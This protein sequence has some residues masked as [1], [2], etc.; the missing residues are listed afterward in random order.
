MD[1]GPV[2]LLIVEFPGN[3]FKGE[4]APALRDLVTEGTVRVLDLLFVYKDADG[5]VGSVELAGLGPD[6]QPAFAD[7]DGQLGGGLLDAE[8][9]AQVGADLQPDS[10]AALD[11]LGEHMGGPLRHRDGARRRPCRRPGPD[12][13]RGG[14]PRLESA[15]P[16]GTERH[17]TARDGRTHR[18]RRGHRDARRRQRPAPPTAPLGA[19][20]RGAAAAAATA[21]GASPAAGLRPRSRPTPHQRRRT[22]RLRRHRLRRPV[23][24]TWC[25]SCSG[26]GTC[27]PRAPSP[28]RSS[29]RP[30][31]SC[32]AADRVGVR[33]WCE[34]WT[35]SS[36]KERLR[37]WGASGS[38][39]GARPPDAAASG[40]GAGPHPPGD[41]ARRPDDDAAHP[42][43]DH[44]GGADPAG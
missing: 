28:T 16:K 39:A 24:T 25:R 38:R 43:A 37:A 10:S 42:C 31:P 41:G 27:T 14:R 23:G 29:R 6:L 5:E 33:A 44:A 12:P 2:D 21:A 32:S 40:H 20:G 15:A 18:R 26:S 22:P 8:D 19:E 11:R 17:G 3:Q 13:G 7:L 35:A 36:R 4:I 34:G 1:V 30:R 9:V